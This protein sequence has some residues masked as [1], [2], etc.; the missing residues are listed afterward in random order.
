M[1]MK[2][3]IGLITFIIL[4]LVVLARVPEARVLRATVKVDGMSC[5]FCT[6]GVEKRLKK[7]EGVGLVS[8]DLKSGTASVTSVKDGSIDLRAIPFAVKK[9]GFTPG[10]V[11]AVVRGTVKKGSDGRFVLVSGEPDY[12]FNM[13]GLSEIEKEKLGKFSSGKSPVE[14]EGKIT[15]FGKAA[16]AMEPLEIRGDLR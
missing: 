7:V 4:T 14:I 9:A 1:V 8:V 3:T 5:P 15:D 13:V 11:K 16:L 2:K 10:E 12:V 6:Y